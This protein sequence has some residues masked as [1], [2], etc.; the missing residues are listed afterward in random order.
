M[1][2]AAQTQIPREPQYPTHANGPPRVARL[3]QRTQLRSQERIGVLGQCHSCEGWVSSLSG[4]S[5]ARGRV[6][7]RAHG[8]VD[9]CGIVDRRV[10]REKEVGATG[11]RVGVAIHGD[12]PSVRTCLGLR[13]VR[14]G[15]TSNP[16]HLKYWT[17][18]RVV[19]SDD[20]VLTSLEHELTLMDPS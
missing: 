18:R 13:G 5:T 15:E 8:R 17:R 6:A 2:R 1:W 4:H 20:D 3:D 19:D 11:R 9:H 16:G 12:E 7:R 14:V 10:K